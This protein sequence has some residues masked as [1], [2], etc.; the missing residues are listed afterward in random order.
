ME[1]NYEMLQNEENV[2]AGT[3]GALLFSLVGGVLWFGL[4]Q[5]GYLAAISGLV[6]VICAIKGYAVFAKK[7]SVKGIVISIIAS[8]IVLLIAWY[9]CLSK[10]VLSAYKEWYSQGLVDFVPSF[11]E[12]VKSAYVFLEEPEIAA[13]YIKDLVLGLLLCAIGS[14]RYIVKSIGRIKSQN[15]ALN[16]NTL[17]TYSA[18]NTDGE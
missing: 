17:N 1:N 3:V 2:L 15:D 8:V 18:E 9:L 6:G 5:A 4:Y 11:S 10:D 16:T 7:E 14:G 12:C 13:E